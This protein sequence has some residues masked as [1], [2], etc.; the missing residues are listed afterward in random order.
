MKKVF[1]NIISATLVVGLLSVC[2]AITSSCSSSKKA[3]NM[4]KVETK[5]SSKV[6]RNYK[7]KGNKKK[8]SATYRSY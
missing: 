8:H 2:G 7:V 1:K 5:K 3:G 6:N 4:Y